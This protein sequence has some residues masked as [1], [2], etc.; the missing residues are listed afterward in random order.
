LAARRY[1]GAAPA[2]PLTPSRARRRHDLPVSEVRGAPVG[3]IEA[4]RAP[5]R[6]VPQQLP[7]EGDEEVA[8]LKPLRRLEGA[9]PGLDLDV[10]QDVLAQAAGAVA[11]GQI[12]PALAVV[13]VVEQ[14]RPGDRDS[15]VPG[16]DREL[17]AG[18]R[19]A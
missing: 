16:L 11:G 12:V 19:L 15:R 10:H 4:H 8:N 17:D 7:G 14:I 18:R 1:S 5:R 9:L 2:Q 3:G 6:A 13:V